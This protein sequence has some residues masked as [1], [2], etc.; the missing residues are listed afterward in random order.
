MAFYVS[1][2]L[3]CVLNLCRHVCI[4]MIYD[5]SPSQFVSNGTDV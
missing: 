5:E 1:C 3:I 4:P 2:Q